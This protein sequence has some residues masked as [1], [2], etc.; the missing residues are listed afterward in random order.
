[1]SLHPIPE[2]QMLE[3]S[4]LEDP[5]RRNPPSSSASLSH[6]K[7][8]SRF[9]R[10]NSRQWSEI[11][12]FWAFIQKAFW[13]FLVFLGLITLASS[14]W[15]NFHAHLSS[16]KDRFLPRPRPSLFTNYFTHGVSPVPCHSHNDYWRRVP[17]LSALEAGCTSVEA[18]IWL[19]NGL[20]RVG[21]TRKTVLRGQT[22]QS[23]YLNPL[24]E[25][26]KQ[27]NPQL[28]RTSL[29][30]SSG[31]TFDQNEEDELVG[32]F[33][34]DPKQTLVLLI[35]FKSGEHLWEYLIES[36][37]SFREHGLLTFS[38][39]SDVIS[40]PITIVVTG[41]APFYRVARNT[42]HDIFY[43]APLDGLSLPESTA[44][45]GHAN[46]PYSPQNSYYASVDFRKAIGSLPLSR[47]SQGQLVKLRN[48]IRDAHGRG[49]KVRYWGTPSWPV[50][51]RNY[52]WR[53]LVR[54]G[55][56]MLNVDDLNAAT[57]VDWKETSWW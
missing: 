6:H 29:A 56:D 36:L 19:E 4:D 21:H 13:W 44:S 24:L 55:V 35:D 43:D 45:S 26:L 47:L 30:F 52:V 16:S 9:S 51:L 2:D 15:N 41:D 39:G 54:E 49:L 1:M 32:I 53:V 38:N 28:N 14:A 23:L 48:Q 42:Y 5:L 57:K 25:M 10:R 27:H 37:H 8:R 18:D 34:T 3:V 20:L 46:V 12:I 11:A 17:L 7:R 40:R 33:A 31:S 50:N 22:L